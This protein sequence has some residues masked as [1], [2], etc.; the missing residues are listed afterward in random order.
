MC[1]ARLA[2]NVAPKK[3]Q[4]VAILAPSHNFVGLSLRTKAGIDNRE[5]NLLNSNVSPTCRHYIENFGPLVAEICWRVWDTTENFNGFRV[6]AALL[7]GT[8]VEGVSQSLRR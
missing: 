4:K 1:C 2:G 5:K 3:C 7:H 6:L 8:L